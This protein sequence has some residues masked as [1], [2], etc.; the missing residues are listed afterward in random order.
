MGRACFLGWCFYGDW[1][2]SLF[3]VFVLFLL[4]FVGMVYARLV[5]SLFCFTWGVGLD[6]V[7]CDIMV[8]G[9]GFG[10]C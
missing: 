3:A 9:L 10:D 2:V 1:F 5:L 7:G 6:L 4:L 8:D